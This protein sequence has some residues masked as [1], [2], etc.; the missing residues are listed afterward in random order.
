MQKYIRQLIKRKESNMTKKTKKL[1][2]IYY[3]NKY[4][5]NL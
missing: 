3:K 5:N 2:Y 4:K 1:V